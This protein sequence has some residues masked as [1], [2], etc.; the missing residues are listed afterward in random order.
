VLGLV[1]AGPIG[2][3]EWNARHVHDFSLSL[4]YQSEKQAFFLIRAM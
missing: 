4:S 3:S 2:G 1:D